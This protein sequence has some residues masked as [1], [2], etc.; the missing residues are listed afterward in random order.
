MDLMW[1][2][3]RDAIVRKVSKQRAESKRRNE[4]GLYG[5]VTGLSSK[6]ER[7]N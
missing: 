5:E 6:D 1:N 3:T 4:N 7:K 2:K